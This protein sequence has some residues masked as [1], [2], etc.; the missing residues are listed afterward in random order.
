M[1]RFGE[2][3]VDCII[4][5]TQ[6][7]WVSG[8][9]IFVQENVSAALPGTQKNTRRLPCTVHAHTSYNPAF[10]LPPLLIPFSFPQAWSLPCTC[11]LVWA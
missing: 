8:Y 3:L 11:P 7:G 6:V 5:L 4:C 2:H 9:L 10:R 1:P